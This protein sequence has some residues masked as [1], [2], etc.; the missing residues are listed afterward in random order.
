MECV[1]HLDFPLRARSRLYGNT[2]QKHLKVRIPREPY[3]HK[4]N[5]NEILRVE[6]GFQTNFTFYNFD[7][8]GEREVTFLCACS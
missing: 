3:G 5:K 1:F 7:D 4:L 2:S 8:E 6:L